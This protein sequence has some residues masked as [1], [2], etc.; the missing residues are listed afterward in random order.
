[1][2]I[3]LVIEVTTARDPALAGSAE[4]SAISSAWLGLGLGL[5][6]GLVLGSGRRGGGGN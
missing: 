6:L 2:A 3:S 5:G 4:S 1:M